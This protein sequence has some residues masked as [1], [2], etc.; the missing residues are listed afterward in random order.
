MNQLND[1]ARRQFINFV[2]SRTK[3]GRVGAESAEADTGAA[4]TPP[5]RTRDRSTEEKDDPGPAPWRKR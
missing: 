4:D 2:A 5:P 3:A 1:N